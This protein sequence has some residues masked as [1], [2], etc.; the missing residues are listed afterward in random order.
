MSYKTLRHLMSLVV[1]LKG[2]S[3]GLTYKEMQE[4]FR[5]KEGIDVSVRNLQRMLATIRDDLGLEDELV[6]MES[7]YHHREK[8]FLIRELP[9]YMVKLDGREQVAIETHIKELEGGTLREALTKVVAGQEPLSVL[10]TN[11]LER[12]VEQTSHAGKAQPTAQYDRSQ[13]RDIETAIIGNIELSFKYRS[14]GAK[15]DLHRQVRP[16]GVVYNRFAYLIA[17]T[18]NREPVSY[19][20]DMLQDVKMTD[21]SFTP[22]EGF[23]FKDWVRESFGVYRGDELLKIQ[24]RFLPDVAERASKIIFHPTQE[25]RRQRDGSL[26]VKIQCRGH[27]ELI[28]ELMHPD[29]LGFVQIESPDR[30]KEEYAD[31]LERAK[32]AV[33]LG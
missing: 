28:W 32:T 25:Q 30:L 15:K 16:I 29:W 5:W 20:M 8:K 22:K 3:V 4:E 17:A 10:Y 23:N 1:I 14:Q 21:I 33:N 27:R 26:I 9:Q 18:G 31:Q 13:M 24:I 12:L 6:E 19:R 7:D 2:R 11:D